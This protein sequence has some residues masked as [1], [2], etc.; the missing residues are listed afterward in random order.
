MDYYAP[1]SRLPPLRSPLRL[2]TSPTEL[3]GAQCTRCHELVTIDHSCERNQ[4]TPDT[5]G[6]PSLSFS[7]YTSHTYPSLSS[8]PRSPESSPRARSGGSTSPTSSSASSLKLQSSKNSLPSAPQPPTLRRK[9][10]PTET[11]LRE[12]RAN[13]RLLQ[14]KQS[15]DQLRQL[16]ERQTMEYLYGDFASLDG[17]RE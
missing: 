9:I 1:G 12:I 5:P 16:Y 13:Q 8:L 17:L 6:A 10:S 4:R 2:R 7:A 11:S 3:D 14:M 15:E